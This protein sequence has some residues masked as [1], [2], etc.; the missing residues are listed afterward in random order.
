MLC[1]FHV[2]GINGRVDEVLVPIHL[3]NVHGASIVGVGEVRVDVGQERSSR[4]LQEPQDRAHEPLHLPG[5]LG[6]RSEGG[7]NKPR[8]AC[9][10]EVVTFMWP[11]LAAVRA[12]WTFSMASARRFCTTSLATLLLME[13]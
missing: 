11:S 8:M 1:H 13:T 12:E 3:A 2:E 9:D 4:A 10:T 7:L 6:G 5:E